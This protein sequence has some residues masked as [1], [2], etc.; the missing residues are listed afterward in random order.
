MFSSEPEGHRNDQRA[1]RLF[2]TKNR[3]QEEL[4]V[5]FQ[6]LRDGVNRRDGKGILM[7][8]HSGRT[9]VLS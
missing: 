6:E 5:T 4:I 7:R 3:L 2:S 8:K 1:R 9:V